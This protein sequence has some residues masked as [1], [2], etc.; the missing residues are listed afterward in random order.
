MP[1]VFLRPGEIEAIKQAIE[2]STA[3]YEACKS[4]VSFAPV[5]D[6]F[7]DCIL[8]QR[9]LLQKLNDLK[10]QSTKE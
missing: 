4:R 1:V 10:N 2:V 5:V 3:F 9:L 8:Q 7:N 6:I